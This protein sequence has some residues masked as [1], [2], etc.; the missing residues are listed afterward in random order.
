MGTDDC[1]TFRCTVFLP[2]LQYLVQL[3]STALPPSLRPSVEAKH[4]PTES[5]R[6]SHNGART[7]EP[8]KQQKQEQPTYLFGPGAFLYRFLLL[9]IF[10]VL[11]LGDYSDVFVL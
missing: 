6:V 5:I 4:L 1:A 8:K 11:D 7:T 10:D 3:L 9:P 2:G